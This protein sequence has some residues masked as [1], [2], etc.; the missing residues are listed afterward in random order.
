[1]GR[2]AKLI[3][4]VEM[5]AHAPFVARQNAQDPRP[6]STALGA[7]EAGQRE[8][9]VIAIA[10]RDRPRYPAKRRSCESG[11]PGR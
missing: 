5:S 3:P 4:V 7:S 6:A 1:M 2:Q 8:S 9:Q 10:L 11:H